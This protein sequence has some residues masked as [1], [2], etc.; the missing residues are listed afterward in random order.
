MK[1]LIIKKKAEVF[2][3]FNRRFY[4]SVDFIREALVS[5]G[6]PLSFHFDFTERIDQILENKTK[7]IL[8][9]NLFSYNSLHVVDLAFHLCGYP[10]KLFSTSSGYSDW[11]KK[12]MIFVGSG[13]SNKN[14]L[15]L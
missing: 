14:S 15:F 9:E 3:G 4:S 1:T 5:E 8:L 2:I 7:K 11:H 10:K 12:P 13:I 6:G